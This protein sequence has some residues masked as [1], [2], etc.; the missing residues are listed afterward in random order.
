[1]TERV[2]SAVI[3]SALAYDRYASKY[4]S[5][6][7][8]NRINAYMRAAMT[9]FQRETFRPRQRLLELGCG[10]GDEAIAL[11]ARGCSVVGID[12][13]KEMVGVAQAK[14][15]ARSLSGSLSFHVGYS[16][17]LGALLESENPGSYDGA[18]SSFALS[19]EADLRPVQEALFRLLRPS[20]IFLAASMNRMSAMEWMLS[21]A[22][23]QPSRAGRRLRPTTE[24]KVGEV[25]TIVYCRTPPQLVHALSP[26][27]SVSRIRG[28]PVVLPPPYANR[29]LQPWPSLLGALGRMDAR[30]AGW[31][32]LN[33]LGDHTVAWFRR[34]DEPFGR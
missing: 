30:V 16:R 6:L 1:M 32:V 17:D 18:Y 23:L 29:P 9:G 22:S 34:S 25:R 26:S 19:Y 33:Y 11:A 7:S 31:P 2:P 21:F 15:R 8:E 28:L 12:P 20:A 14:A 4:D 3:D 10:T 27:F 5:L 13:S 24:H